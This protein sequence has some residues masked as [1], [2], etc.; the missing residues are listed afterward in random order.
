MF[1]ER[2]GG[3]E[4]DEID[5][6]VKKG[7]IKP[8]D[9][10]AEKAERK[11]SKKTGIVSRTLS[12]VKIYKIVPGMKSPEQ[13]EVLAGELFARLV[14]SEPV[15]EEELLELAT[16]RESA[17]KAEIMKIGIIGADRYQTQNPEPAP[18]DEGLSAK[19]L[20]DSIQ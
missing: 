15:P 16:G 17:V 11:K 14:E 4:L 20:L 7:E 2:F 13:S 12:A 6:A 8:R 5:Q 10:A 18:E 19:L 3:K 9:G 1:S